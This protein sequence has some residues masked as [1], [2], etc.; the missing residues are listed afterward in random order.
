MNVAELIAA[1]QEL[2]QDLPVFAT[3]RICYTEPA[4]PTV[5]YVEAVDDDGWRSFAH[6]DEPGA[7]KA[8]II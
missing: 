5:G 7:I 2:P 3:D 6:A 4:T 8:V 1:L